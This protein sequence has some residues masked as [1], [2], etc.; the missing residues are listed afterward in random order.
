MAASILELCRARWCKTH[1]PPFSHV[2][3]WAATVYP[4][5][6]TG[7]EWQD[8]LDA[9]G[10]VTNQG[11]LLEDRGFFAV[12]TGYDH[13]DHNLITL[14]V[15]GLAGIPV[16]F[17]AHATDLDDTAEA[18]TTFRAIVDDLIAKGVEP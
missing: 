13:A 16:T 17:T 8:V 9:S 10:H 4:D 14:E 5:L 15:I 12:E 18:E 2:A 6:A 1:G 7:V 3:R 11:M